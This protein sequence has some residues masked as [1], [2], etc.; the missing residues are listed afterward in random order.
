MAAS[1]CGNNGGECFTID[2]DDDDDDDGGTCE[3]L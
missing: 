2:D 1:V 3:L